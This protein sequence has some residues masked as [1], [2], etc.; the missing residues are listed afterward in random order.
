MLKL[1]LYK[2]S[3]KK[4]LNKSKKNSIYKKKQTKKQKKIIKK[5]KK[6]IKKQKKMKRT[7]KMK[8]NKQRGGTNLGSSFIK[9][10]LLSTGYT[11]DGNITPSTLQ[12]ANPMPFSKFSN[13]PQ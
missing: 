5:Q 3:T 13:C 8:K 12:L 11:L 9:N 10:G 7:K 4:K 6:I 2:K 1:S